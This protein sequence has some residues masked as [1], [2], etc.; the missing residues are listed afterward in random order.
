MILNVS[1]SPSI[2]RT[3]LVSDVKLGT[4]HRPT[5]VV[6]VAGGKGFNVARCLMRL[7]YQAQAIGILGGPNGQT[8][9]ELAR[10]EGLNIL[11]V[12]GSLNTRVCTS[13]MDMSTG[14]LTEFYELATPVTDSEWD[15]LC[16]KVRCHSRSADWV[17]I[18]GAL[19]AGLPSVAILQLIEAAR[20][21]GAE[22]AI[23]TH[24][25]SLQAALGAGPSL[26]KVN[27]LEAASLLSLQE[28]VVASD[29]CEQLARAVGTTAVVTDGEAGAWAMRVDQKALHVNSARRGRYPVGSGD[30]F[31]AGFVAARSHDRSISESLRFAAATA[32][33]NA[34]VPGPGIFDLQDLETLLP[35]TVVT[36]LDGHLKP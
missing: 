2:D 19:P 9:K 29:V 36:T 35:E 7:G 20:E 22:V 16:E 4:I 5:T 32:T 12:P 8:I 15:Q 24:G 28:N 26:M 10:F 3:L 23:D 25:A 6:E 27:R 14:A 11:E 17:T 34:Q 1:L 31:L 13:I 21:F 18:S 30:C 33:A